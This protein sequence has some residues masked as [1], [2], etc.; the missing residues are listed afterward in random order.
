MVELPGDQR[1]QLV[2]APLL[3]GVF[4]LPAKV[5]E[6]LRDPRDGAHVR[7]EKSLVA[8]DHEAAVAG[9]GVLEQAQ[10]LAEVS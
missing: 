6:D 4:D 7:L 9:F 8:R 3:A 5:L 2:E 1:L 10:H